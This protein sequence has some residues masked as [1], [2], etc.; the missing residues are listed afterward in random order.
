MKI[1]KMFLWLLVFPI[2]VNA[3]IK[4]KVVDEKNNPIAYVNIWVESENIGTTAN[5]QG[6]FTI[7]STIDKKLIFTAVGFE[8]LTSKISENG[9]ITLKTHIEE[10]EEVVIGNPKGTEEIELGDFTNGN[11]FS[12]T[13]GP[14]IMAQKMEYNDTI[15]KHKFLKELT[16]LTTSEKDSVK[17]IV[18]FYK[19]NKDG[20]P[21]SDLLDENLIVNLKKGTK[22]HTLDLKSFN[23]KFPKKGLFIGFEW[24]IIEVNKNKN[25]YKDSKTKQKKVFF[26]YQPYLICNKKSDFERY[27]FI[28]GKWN[29]ST[30]GSVDS[31]EKIKQ[32]DIALKLTLTN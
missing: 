4:G 24:M 30:S 31:N 12:F 10:L 8:T 19:P 27:V 18:H 26:D 6:E 17:I 20:F 32:K 25:Q 15:A 11:C 29:N 23:V 28:S 9:V 7:N 21:G 3:Q 5:E 16:F 22:K 14:V 1:K 2:L 13:M